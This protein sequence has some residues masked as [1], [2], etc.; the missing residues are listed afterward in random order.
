VSTDHARHV[1]IDR[2]LLSAREGID[3]ALRSYAEEL[4]ESATEELRRT[5]TA[6]L[7]HLHDAL[8]RQELARIDAEAQ[9]AEARRMVDEVKQAGELDMSEL[10]NAHEAALAAERR[11]ADAEIDDA[12]RTAQAQVDDVQRTLE[13]RVAELTRRLAEADHSSAHNRL[14]VDALRSI[15]EAGSLSGVLERVTESA[16]RVVD[17]VALLL[18]RGQELHV[19]RA[20]GFEVDGRPLA[21]RQVAFEDAGLVAM[22]ARA[23]RAMSGPSTEFP[24]AGRPEFAV[25]DGERSAAAFPVAV[26][27]DV[28]AVVYADAPS[29][30]TDAAPA[31]YH[32]LETLTIY[33]GR[34]LETLTV[35]LAMG[36]G[37][38]LVRPSHE[39]PGSSAVREVK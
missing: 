11:R 4:V 38:S 13:A 7:H 31:W 30:G 33:A 27:G 8:Q 37:S 39:A 16:H 25:R 22:A 2:I 5:T 28:V 20:L 18:I 23:R 3:S 10:Q 12:R 14:L 34:T 6:D 35:Q 26:A 19:W 1:A 15:D 24:D 32:W 29:D 9:L 36:F 17:R 21:P